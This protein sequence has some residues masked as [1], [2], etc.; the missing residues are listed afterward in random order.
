MCTRGTIVRFV[1]ISLI[2]ENKNLPRQTK[3]DLV[4]FSH[5]ICPVLVTLVSEST[6]HFILLSF[7][8]LAK[9]VKL[10]LGDLLLEWQNH[11]LFNSTIDM[12]YKSETIN[13]VGSY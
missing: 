10:R 13:V 5:I 1:F 7:V 12:D 3:A 2:P 8:H 9:A 11:D 4:L 6:I